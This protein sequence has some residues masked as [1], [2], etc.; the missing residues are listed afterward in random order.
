[1]CCSNACQPFVDACEHRKSVLALRCQNL[2]FLPR[3]PHHGSSVAS[4]RTYFAAVLRHSSHR[5]GHHNDHAGYPHAL[6]LR[7][8]DLVWRSSWEQ[9]DQQIAVAARRGRGLWMTLGVQQTVVIAADTQPALGWLGVAAHWIDFEHM[10]LEDL[11]AVLLVG[12]QVEVQF[13]VPAE[14]QALGL[15][16]LLVLE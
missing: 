12:E 15:G 8:Q 1:M 14:V 4:V 3:F 16:Q 13:G 6:E 5:K 9:A 10:Q 2:A 11:C 7:V